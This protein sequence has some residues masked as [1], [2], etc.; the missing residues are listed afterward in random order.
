[1]Q[2]SHTRDPSR[3][4]K[5]LIQAV[6]SATVQIQTGE[7]EEYYDHVTPSSHHCE[8]PGES[9]K[10]DWVI[11]SQTNEAL[12]CRHSNM[13]MTNGNFPALGSVQ[14]LP[15]LTLAVPCSGDLRL[16]S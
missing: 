3:H 4:S 1:M 14:L 15:F 7:S 16:G 10:P 12:R 6:F 8:V 9:D 11:I 13:T 2:Q 5:V